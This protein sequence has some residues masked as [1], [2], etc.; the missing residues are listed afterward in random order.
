MCVAAGLVFIAINRGDD[1]SSAND[2]PSSVTDEPAANNDAMLHAPPVGS[3]YDLRADQVE[4]ERVPDAEPVP[5]TGP[6]TSRTVGVVEVP[7]DADSDQQE[8]ACFEEALRFLDAEPVLFIRSL[9]NLGTYTP[10]RSDVDAGA[11]WVRCDVHMGS[12]EYPQLP[13]QVKAAGFQS[14]ILDPEVDWCL[15]KDGA[16]LP[17]SEPHKYDVSGVPDVDSPESYPGESELATIADAMCPEPVA[18]WYPS[19]PPIWEAGYRY[20]ICWG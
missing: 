14:G 7:P 1:P 5:C 17:C 11:S 2:D 4:A 9:L 8:V 16:S 10:L 19:T 6:H 15:L 3:C 20:M 13:D 18:L 12:V